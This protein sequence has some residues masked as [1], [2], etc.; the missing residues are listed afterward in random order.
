[1]RKKIMAFAGIF[2]D[3]SESDYAD[4]KRETKQTRALLFDRKF[5]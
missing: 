5:E 2:S 4:F 3:M 1:M